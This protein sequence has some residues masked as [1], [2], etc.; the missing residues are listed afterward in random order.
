MPPTVI[1]PGETLEDLDY[2]NATIDTLL[3]SAFVTALDSDTVKAVKEIADT[4]NSTAQAIINISEYLALRDLSVNVKII[5]AEIYANPENDYDLRMAAY[6]MIEYMQLGFDEFLVYMV[7]EKIQEKGEDV[8][9]ELV[10]HLWGNALSYIGLGSFQLVGQGIRIL[11]NSLFDMD[12]VTQT[13]YQLGAAVKLE[14]CI[15]KM[16]INAEPDYLRYENGAIAEK[17]LN[18]IDMYKASLLKEYDYCMPLFNDD[19]KLIINSEK[20]KT[21]HEF[22]AIDREAENKY[23][24]YYNY[25]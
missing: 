7:G 16:V 11:G 18:V 25:S 22:A 9:G 5:L 14:R 6:E 13:Y 23:N 19:D 8:L 1:C 21:S 10:D 17:Y 12:A 15:R 3:K 24:S 2:D 4:A 20:E